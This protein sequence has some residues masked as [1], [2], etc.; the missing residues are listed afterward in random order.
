ATIRTEIKAKQDLKPKPELGKTVDV[1]GV[2]VGGPE[3]VFV[4]NVLLQRAERRFWGGQIQVVTEIGP[5]PPKGGAAPVGQIPIK[6]DGK[7]N[8]SA[9]LLRRGA[10]AVPAALA[11][12][13]GAVAA[14][15]A[16]FGFSAVEDG[17]A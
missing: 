9:E 10:V 16:D 11:D 6:I 4:W 3:E 15:M 2:A 1:K 12:R 13:A 5:A 14:L 7:G 8:A 17:S